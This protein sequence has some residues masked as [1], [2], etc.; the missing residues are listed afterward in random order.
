GAAGGPGG[1]DLR[2]NRR[3]AGYPG[4]HG[5]VAARTR[6][7]APAGAD[8]LRRRRQERPSGGAEG[9]MTGRRRGPA[10]RLPALAEG[11]LA[12]AA[13]VEVAELLAAAPAQLALAHQLDDLNDELRERYADALTEP[14][15][16]TIEAKIVRFGR[17]WPGLPR[18][19]ARIAAAI[20][21]VSVAAA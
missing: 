12:P 7:R 1:A 15:S 8:G 16:P 14:L 5:H 6:P 18:R 4:R 3:R 17:G 2:R 20:L 19:L 21:V 13:R 10:A 9:Q 11:E